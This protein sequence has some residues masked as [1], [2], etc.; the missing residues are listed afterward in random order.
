LNPAHDGTATFDPPL[1]GRFGEIWRY[2]IQGTAA[3]PLVADGRVF[4][5]WAESGPT[6]HQHLVALDEANGSALWET[7]D[8]AD[9]NFIGLAYENGRVFAVDY[10]GLL[11][12]FD[13]ATG[14]L[15][16]SVQLPGQWLFTSS[17]SVMD[18]VVFVGGAGS[19]GTVYAL[20]ASN[21]ALLWTQEVWNGDDSSPAIADGNVFVSY[22]C[23]Q[24][25]SL[26]TVSGA[27]NW[28]YSGPCE[29]GGGATPV[30]RDHRLYVRDWPSAPS[31][32]VFDS[33]TGDL[34]N[35]IDMQT[36][37]AIGATDGY[38]LQSGTLRG[39]ELDDLSV[40][41][42]FAGDGQ[43]GTAPIVVDDFVFIGSQSGM[44]Y[45]LDVATGHVR[46]SVNTGA[47]I[48]PTMDGF[49]M[50]SSLSAGD[51]LVLVPTAA[52]IVAYGEVPE[53]IFADGFESP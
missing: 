17:P 11:K 5:A 20:D 41:W 30:V 42:S 18:G 6:Y 7:V 22:V 28:H 46:F 38:F 10:D 4:V 8:L 31:G 12:T 40:L 45:A 32:Y 36:T 2:A 47:S 16:W 39:V 13:A 53:A 50:M 15:D 26:D 1:T 52:A 3:Y 24:V 9:G 25:Y 35:R 21:G 51:G 43:L 29:G 44:L 27:T 48:A 23:P 49:G 34:L 19:A 33:D 37:P 14:D